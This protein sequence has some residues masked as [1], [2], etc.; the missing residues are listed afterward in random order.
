MVLLRIA[1]FAGLPALGLLSLSLLPGGL[2]SEQGGALGSGAGEIPF[3]DVQVS[4]VDG[5]A[6][7]PDAEFYWRTDLAAATVE[8]MRDKLPLLVVFR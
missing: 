8:A 2:L 3:S 4:G 6:P 5:R 1:A 7:S